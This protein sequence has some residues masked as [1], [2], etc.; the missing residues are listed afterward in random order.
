MTHDIKKSDIAKGPLAWFACNHVAVNIFMAFLLAAGVISLYMIKVEVFPRTDTDIITIAVPYLGASPDEVEEGVC[1]RIE[2]VIAGVEGIKRIRSTA[3]E[4]SGTV[5]VELEDYADDSQVLDDIKN[6]VD[7][8]DTFPKD[9]DQPVI[10]QL[11]NRVQV[12]MLAIYGTASEKT[13]KET[14]DRIRDELTAMDNIS[15]VEP[16]GIRDYE[17]SIEVSEE[18]LRRYNLSFNEVSAAIR[19]ASLDL[20]AGSVKTHGGEI[21]IRTKG[22][23]YNALEFDDVIVRTNN[24]GTHIYLNDI[25]DVIDGFEDT[26]V[27]TFFDGKRAALLKV[28]RVGDQGAMDVASTVRKYVS[29]QNEVLPDKISV[30]AWSD[31]SVLL[32]GRLTLM[33]KNAALGLVLVFLCLTLFLDL[34]LAFWTTMGIPISFLGSIWLLPHLGVSINMISL[35]AFIIVLGI[36]VDDAI[37]VGENIFSYRQRGIAGFEAAVM[38]VREMCWPVTFAILTTIVAFAPLTIIQGNMGKVVNTIPKVVISVLIISLFEALIILPAHLAFKNR[39]TSPG[40]IANLQSYIRD[41]LQWFIDKPYV[42]SLKLA[43]KWRYV[44]LALAVG[45]MLLTVGVVRSGLVKWKFFP[46]LPADNIFAYLTMPQGTALEQTQRIVDRIEDA[47]Q[48]LREEFENK[49]P[50]NPEKVFQHISVVIGDQ[51]SKM[52]RG[53]TMGID[54]GVGG[55]YLAEVNIEL[56]DGEVRRASSDKM[57][58][59][60]AELVGDVPGVSSLI[61]DA[62]LL[63]AG[64]PI[65]IELSHHDFATLISAAERLKGML[66]EYPGVF[67]ISDDFEPGKMELKLGLTQRGRNAGL[68]LADLAMQVRQGFYGEEVQRIQRGRDDLKVML[69]YPDAERRSYADIENMRIR[70]RDGTELPFHDVATVDEGQGYAAINRVNRQRVIT[71]SADVDESVKGANAEEINKKLRANELPELQ[72]EYFGLKCDFGGEQREQAETVSSIGINSTVALLVIFGLLGIQF[73]SYIQPIIIMIAIPFGIVGAV[74]GHMI[75]GYNLSMLSLLGIV[76]LS[77][78]VVNDALIMIDLINRERKQGSELA[79][80]LLDSGTRRFRP[81]LLTSATTF[82]G[83]MPMILETSLQAKFMIPMAVSLGFGVFFATGI[84][85]VLVPV[86]YQISED[87]KSLVM[88]NGGDEENGEGEIEGAMARTGV[89]QD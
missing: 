19:G 17:I 76:A 33:L 15:Q 87:V 26:D 12:I 13:L 59:R 61:F 74:I 7:R 29:E 8:I 86:L 35:F 27:A 49:D 34:R 25:A 5:I 4:N 65:N 71:V 48:V 2:E 53:P 88:N 81:I 66:R 6:E 21:L 67:E 80:V 32:R 36:V 30:A 70:L 69:R 72:K 24:D 78:V 64:D 37:V 1:I 22:Q 39:A 38:G 73:K 83:L 58:T 85:L 41:R 45:V 63:K 52:F 10:S 18:N 55:A 28:F 11:L 3:S 56:V 42:L 43:I 14:A 84:T 47:A 79:H 57:A 77:G 75:M 54:R 89:E 9:A 16:A 23:R 31:L 50:D 46:S 60:W 44:T 40:P 20:P 62:D 51:P 82:F 68:T